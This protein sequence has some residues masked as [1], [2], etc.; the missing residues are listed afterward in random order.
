MSKP[1]WG[2]NPDDFDAKMSSSSSSDDSSGDGFSGGFDPTRYPPRR[3]W[4]PKGETRLV[5]F[6]DWLS[7]DAHPDGGQPVQEY[8]LRIDGDWRNWF[9]HDGTPDDPTTAAL[10]ERHDKETVKKKLSNVFYSTVVVDNEWTDKDGKVHNYGVELHPAKF[11]TY[12]KFMMD[13]E[14]GRE[15]RN[16][17]VSMDR[18]DSPQSAGAGMTDQIEREVDMAK[19]FQHAEYQGRKLKDLWERAE[20]DASFMEK[21]AKVFALEFDDD[22][23]L[24]HKLVPFNYM[25][26]LK[27]PT[28]EEVAEAMRGYREGNSVTD[29]VRGNG[30]SGGKSSGFDFGGGGFDPDLSDNDIP[31]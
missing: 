21:L 6:V 19:A 15:Y 9:T 16:H 2:I 5:I 27:P 18:A 14:K 10:L 29:K 4:M 20:N 11:Y 25:E 24:L 28:E 3:F 30:K 8:Q 31:F 23:N 22:G 7:N 12:Q 17:A 1:A 13:R 26:V